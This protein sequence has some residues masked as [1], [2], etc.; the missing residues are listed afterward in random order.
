M[1]GVRFP[2]DEATFRFATEF[3]A[4][5]GAHLASYPKAAW[6]KFE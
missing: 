5:L 1:A 2:A 4:V 6:D 3:I